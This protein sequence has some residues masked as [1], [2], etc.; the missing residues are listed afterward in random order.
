MKSKIETQLPKD[1]HNLCE[2]SFEKIYVAD[3]KNTDNT[4]GV[5]VSEEHPTIGCVCISNENKI[6]II[7][8][9]FG[10][11]ALPVKKGTQCKQCECVLFPS[12][13]DNHWI[14]F[15]ET[16]YAEDT[17]LAFRKESD[18]PYCMVSQI[19]DTIA[20]FRSK[21]I[22][23]IN[24]NVHAI[25][26]FPNLKENY[27]E[28]FFAALQESELP[29]SVEDIRLKHKITI[30]ACNTATVISEKRLRLPVPSE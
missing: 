5:E 29:I 26:S 6:S 28:V 4:R 30:R 19:I 1:K 21:S 13:N 24:R 9:G 14:L 12:S 7:F 15:I 11:N 2:I 23:E 22:I 18:Y 3:W 27:H 20:Y 10:E 17:V 16:K 25:V 8:D